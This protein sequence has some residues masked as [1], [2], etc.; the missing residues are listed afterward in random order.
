MYAWREV[1]SYPSIFKVNVARSFPESIRHRVCHQPQHP[2]SKHVA[3]HAFSLC[4]ALCYPTTKNPLPSGITLRA[5]HGHHFRRHTVHDCLL[6][7]AGSHQEALSCHQPQTQMVIL[8]V[9]RIGLL[10]NIPLSM[11][12]IYA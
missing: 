8:T 4:G 6:T 11:H 12:G 9:Q 5:Q 10:I 3:V 7:M 2:W 1:N